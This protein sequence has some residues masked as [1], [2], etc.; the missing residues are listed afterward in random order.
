M[1]LQPGGVIQFGFTNVT[2]LSFT[3]LSSTNLFMPST[4]WTRLG[5]VT[6]VAPGQFQFRDA[7]LTNVPTRFY[8]VASP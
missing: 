4:N 6:E 3:A 1:T 7:V 8:Q 5:P 2:G